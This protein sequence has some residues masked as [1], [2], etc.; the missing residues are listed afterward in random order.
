[1]SRIGAKAHRCMASGL[2]LAS[3][4]A[5]VALAEGTGSGVDSFRVG[6]EKWVETRQ[7]ISK[8]DAD[9]EVDREML[10][11]TKDLLAQ[12]KQ[13]LAAEIEE[14]EASSTAADEER[15]EL[16]LK[17]G[18]YQRSNGVLLARIRTLEQDVVSLAARLPGPLR[19]KLE[20]LLVQ[21]P[22]DP[23]SSNQSLGQRLMNVLGV[24]SQTDKWNSTASFV[25]ETR[26]VGD[27]KLQVRTLYW[28]LA[29]AFYVDSQGR[30]AGVG[31]PGPEGWEFSDDPGLA[32]DARRL[33]DIYQG[34]VD[35]IE[36][37][38]L[39]VEIH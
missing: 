25:A 11:S 5:S 16:L 28:G 31:R 4:W 35:L 2:F 24:L 32:G 29:Q 39:P 12:Q 20:M 22:E 6:M 27:Q 18:E 33:L 3:V 13:A 8:E 30:I 23:E 38:E 36:F 37:V 15:R 1:M 7:L 21:I 26:A 14:L 19:E 17:R 10:R 9:W 34:N